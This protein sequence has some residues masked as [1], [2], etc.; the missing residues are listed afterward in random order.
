MQGFVCTALS[1][2]HTLRASVL[3]SV[4]VMNDRI[5]YEIDYDA[6]GAHHP[7]ERA[8]DLGAAPSFLRGRQTAGVWTDS[9]MQNLRPH[10]P[11]GF[12]IKILRKPSSIVDSIA[13]LICSWQFCL[14]WTSPC[15]S[16]V[17]VPQVVCIHPHLSTHEAH[18]Q[19]I[20]SVSSND[21][22]EIIGPARDKPS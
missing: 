11:M 16:H 18:M 12:D 22:V 5:C 19:I 15:L 7:S 3:H 13:G 1:S 9:H 20:R 10:Q 21:C 4:H 8:S 14:I 17:P 2:H 6:G